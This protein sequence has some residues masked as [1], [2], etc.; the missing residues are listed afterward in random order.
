VNEDI[1]LNDLSSIREK[2]PNTNPALNKLF[3][4]NFVVFGLHQ[5]NV[6]IK[7]CPSPIAFIKTCQIDYLLIV[8]HNSGVDVLTPP[9]FSATQKILRHQEDWLVQN[10]Q[11]S[12]VYVYTKKEITNATAQTHK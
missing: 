7:L 6:I 2:K 11:V 12:L 5:A 3:G 1:S 4:I 9:R 8:R 10:R